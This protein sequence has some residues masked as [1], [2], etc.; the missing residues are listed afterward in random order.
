[1]ALVKLVTEKKLDLDAPV[2]QYIPEFP[3]KKFAFTTRQLAT[4]TAGIRHYR[5]NDPADLTKID[6]FQSATDALKVFKDDSLLFKP[7]DKFYYSS[8]GWNLIGA[9]IEQVSK[10]S[11]VKYMDQ[12]IWK[13]WKMN[14]TYADVADSS[15]MFKSKFYLATGEESPKEDLSYKYPGGGLLSTAEDLITFG[16]ALLG[17]KKLSHEQVALLMEPYRLADGTLS[18]YG[19]GWYTGRDQHGKRI[20][21]HAGDLLNSS[22]WLLLY[23]DEEIVI[24]FLA[25]SQQGVLMDVRQIGALFYRRE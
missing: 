20:W 17:E 18:P 13:P 10:T 2:Q 7:G 15:M 21:Y 16:N 23:P 14:S 19:L 1:V 8:F 9:V 3:K 25:N 24:A 4:H 22:A 11:Y 5:D 12:N 6:H